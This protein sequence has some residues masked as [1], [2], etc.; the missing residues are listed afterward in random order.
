MTIFLFFL[1]ALSS[2][3]SLDT[4]ARRNKYTCVLCDKT[5]SCTVS[6]VG[7]KGRDMLYGK[8][9]LLGYTVY[10]QYEGYE[11]TTK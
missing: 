7:K 2:T 11:R 4:L 9:S 1:L 10:C 5:G 8:E 6:Y 3:C